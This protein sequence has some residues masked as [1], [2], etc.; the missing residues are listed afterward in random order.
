[1]QMRII[2]ENVLN[3]VVLYK[4][5]PYIRKNPSRKKTLNFSG[6]NIIIRT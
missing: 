1:M 6:N 4:R 5:K 3:Y 2:T